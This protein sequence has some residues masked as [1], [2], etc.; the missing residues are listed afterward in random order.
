MFH[1]VNYNRSWPAASII[2]YSKCIRRYRERF[3]GT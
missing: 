1:L 3:L 2:I